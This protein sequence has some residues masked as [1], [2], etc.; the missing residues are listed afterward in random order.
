MYPFLR[1][2]GALQGPQNPQIGHNGAC[3]V[4]RKLGEAPETVHTSYI[5]NSVLL[6]VCRVYRVSFWNLW[7]GELAPEDHEH[8]V[9]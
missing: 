5:C 6:D 3:G 9:F 8:I 7:V 1:V 2:L 4:P